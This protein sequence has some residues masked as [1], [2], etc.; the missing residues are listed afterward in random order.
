MD[1]SE[2][3]QSLLD[4]ID[5]DI[6][7]VKIRQ[8]GRNYGFHNIYYRR[9]IWTKLLG[10]NQ[11]L[12]YQEREKCLQYDQLLKDVHRSLNTISQVKNFKEIDQLR[13][14]L[15]DVLDSIFSQC[16]NFSYYQGYHD[17][18]SILIL[19]LGV[20][21]GYIASIYAAQNFFKDYL[22]QELATTITPQYQ[23]IR[24]LLLRYSRDTS[25]QKLN[26]LM[27]II[28]H[29]TCV[30]PWILTW[31]SHSLDNLNDIS[32]I[33]DFLFCSQQN[34]ILYVCAAFIA[35]HYEV[36]DLRDEDN[37]IGE[38]QEYFQNLNNKERI[39]DIKL[40]NIL[41]LAQQFESKYK[42]DLICQQEHIQFSQNSIVYQHN[43]K[44]QL[45]YYNSLDQLQNSIPKK[46]FNY[47]Q[48]RQDIIL[49]IGGIALSYLIQYYIV[50]K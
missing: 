10:I 29:P 20:E 32:R 21:Q 39:Q 24:N 41:Q 31:F 1:N 2:N 11:Q 16:P 50:K 4:N 26:Q 48:E 49:N 37:L 36:L 28:E 17:V 25:N 13:K 23:F 35:I 38:F 46:V 3:L 40:E 6:G 19:V 30:I 9:L 45:P 14:C 7:Y 8:Y 15:M 34:S 5:N 12:P 47:I 42:F 43:F 18:V 33:W 44:S 27:T 22:D